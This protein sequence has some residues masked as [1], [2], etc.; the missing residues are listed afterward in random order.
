[1]P[2][3][4]S[5]PLSSP[6]A[7]AADA[8][9]SDSTA[10]LLAAGVVRRPRRGILTPFRRDGV[11]D[12]ANGTGG[13]LIRSAVGQI[14]GTRCRSPHAQG[15]LPWRSDFGSLFY[16]AR[17][18]NNDVVLAELVQQWAIDALARWLSCV[19][20]TG[21]ALLRL[22]DTEGNE[23]ILAARI[24]YNVVTRG[25]DVLGRDATTVELGTLRAS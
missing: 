19:R 10:S 22:R 20:V 1:M 24:A 5:W 4:Y 16:L 8:D 2:S 11:S 13:A 15:E 21:V 18:R 17:H 7:P 3:S 9:S 14:L 12:F 23:N 6:P 25:G